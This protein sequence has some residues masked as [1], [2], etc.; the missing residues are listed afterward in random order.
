[1]VM[2][3]SVVVVLIDAARRCLA[4]LRGAPLPPKAVGPAVVPE[5]VPQ[6]CC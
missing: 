2:M 3:V 5:G 1:V 4:T 6:R